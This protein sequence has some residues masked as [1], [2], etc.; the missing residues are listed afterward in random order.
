TS[1]MA[2][3]SKINYA[4]DNYK[5]LWSGECFEGTAVHENGFVSDAGNVQSYM[6][7]G[8][9]PM[10]ESLPRSYI[11]ASAI[12]FTWPVEDTQK[13]IE[14]LFWT[15]EKRRD[16]GLTREELDAGHA[17]P[18]GSEFGQQGLSAFVELVE[19]VKVNPSEILS[20]HVEE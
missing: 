17:K 5:Y 12:L 11:G 4:K 14:S 6:R 13:Y 2:D 8:L 16:L 20:V 3:W 9:S 15:Y 18:G 7:M 1:T 10:L 19:L